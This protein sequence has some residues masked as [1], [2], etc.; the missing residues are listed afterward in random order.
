[1][2]FSS[3]VYSPY[4]NIF[5]HWFP[6]GWRRYLWLQFEHDRGAVRAMDAA[7][8]II[9]IFSKSPWS[10][11]H[12]TRT[13]LVRFWLPHFSVPFPFSVFHAFLFLL[14]LLLS[15]WVQSFLRLLDNLF[16]FVILFFLIC[17]LSCSW[18]I[19]LGL[20]FGLLS[21]SSGPK[22]STRMIWRTSSWSATPCSPRPRSRKESTPWMLIC[23][24]ILG[25]LDCQRRG[26]ETACRRDRILT[27][28]FC[29]SIL[30]VS[31]LVLSFVSCLRSCLIGSSSLFVLIFC[32]LPFFPLCLFLSVFR[33]LLSNGQRYSKIGTGHHSIVFSSP[34]DGAPVVFV[35]GGFIIPFNTPDM[36]TAAQRL[37]SPL[38]LLVA[39]PSTSKTTTK[40]EDKTVEASGTWIWDDGKALIQ[41]SHTQGR[42][43]THALLFLL[44]SLFLPSVC[45]C[46]LILL[47]RILPFS[48]LCLSSYFFFVSAFLSFLIFVIGPKDIILLSDQYLCFSFCVLS[49]RFLLLP[50]FFSFLCMQ[51]FLW[52]IRMLL[53]A[54]ISPCCH[55]LLYLLRHPLYIHWNGR[56]K[57][58]MRSTVR[59]G[60]ILYDSTHSFLRTFPLSFSL[61]FSS[62]PT[63]KP[64]NRNHTLL[65]LVPAGFLFCFPCWMSL[66]AC[67]C[68][69]FM[70][71]RFPLKV[72]VSF[73]P[74]IMS[75]F[76]SSRSK[77][78]TTLAPCTFSL[79]MYAYHLVDDDALSSSLV[80]SSVYV[81]FGEFCARCRLFSSYSSLSASCFLF[82]LG[83]FPCI[84]CLLVLFEISN[85]THF[86]LSISFLF[87][88]QPSFF[89]CLPSV[90]LSWLMFRSENRSFFLCWLWS[91]WTWD[92]RR[93]YCLA[94]CIVHVSHGWWLALVHGI[95]KGP[96]DVASSGK[97]VSGNQLIVPPSTQR[98]Q[99]TWSELPTL[100]HVHACSLNAVLLTLSHLFLVWFVYLSLPS[101]ALNPRPSPDGSFQLSKQN[102]WCARSLVA[103]LLGSFFPLVCLFLSLSLSHFFL[104][105]FPNPYS[106][107]SPIIFQ[108]L[109]E[110]KW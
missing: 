47:L 99:R 32:L 80:S 79:R 95:Q 35:R 57:E 11:R 16:V 86:F 27:S 41:P 90:R 2:A 97:R 37:S 39:L 62:H 109:W 60:D 65:V 52:I 10:I 56:L 59:F 15:G 78:T 72:L 8:I 50:L 69:S 58:T 102:N 83:C 94:W 91:W 45:S 71:F 93:N 103:S 4:L 108:F 6:D 74:L 101:P 70:V 28:Y 33:Y 106:L 61:P 22:I 85:V 67:A 23:L 40:D 64:T 107:L 30:F 63:T 104:F 84:L 75:F 29:Q 92:Q 12:P 7:G 89:V 17:I 100:S 68:F 110:L 44:P 96:Q 24:M 13:L 26:E 49:P 55:H 42:E 88:S 43:R 20:C 18:L 3:A 76:L 82:V 19:N 34:L 25:W 73:V 53:L 105:S 48:F 9:S 46:N 31:F 36:N 66:V 77:R 1:M 87:L 38:H 54:L 81:Q 98:G 14:P 21:S 51:V 5:S